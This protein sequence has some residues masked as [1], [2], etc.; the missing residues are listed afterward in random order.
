LERKIELIN[1]FIETIKGKNTTHLNFSFAKTKFIDLDDFIQTV[2]NHHS[3]MFVA[4]GYNEKFVLATHGTKF[5]FMQRELTCRS[6]LEIM[7]TNTS[8]QGEFDW[9]LKTITF[10]DLTEFEKTTRY[11]C[12]LLIAF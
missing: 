5:N 8:V 12:R 10:A 7:L 1:T 2:F 3:K 6:I 4:F 9:A 11:D